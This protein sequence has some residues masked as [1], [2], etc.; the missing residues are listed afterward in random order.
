MNIGDLFAQIVPVTL[1]KE[2]RCYSI[3]NNV[4]I[5]RPSDT[6]ATSRTFGSNE[7]QLQAFI[8]RLMV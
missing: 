1:L 5:Q 3:L 7:Q 6:S 4:P 2:K 8:L